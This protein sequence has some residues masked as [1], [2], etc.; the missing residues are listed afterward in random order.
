[1]FSHGC[2][3]SADDCDA[4]ML[5]FLARGYRVVVHDRRGHGRPTQTGRGHDIHYAHGSVLPGSL[6]VITISARGSP[7]LAMPLLITHEAISPRTTGS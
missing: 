1:V 4:Q 7:I 3:P 6:S 2:P 5:F